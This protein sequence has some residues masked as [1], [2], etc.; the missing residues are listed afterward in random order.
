MMRRI[1][2]GEPVF[3]VHNCSPERIGKEM[4][5]EELH[6]FAVEVLMSE[7]GETKSRVL[8]YDKQSSFE[9]DF[10]FMNSGKIPGFT[11]DSNSCKTVNVLVVYKDSLDTDISDIDTTWLVEDYHR[12]GKIPR[13]TIATS[14]CISDNSENGKP[15]ICGGQFCFIYHSIGLVPDEINQP[16]DKELSAVELAS[17]YAEAWDKKDAS[18]VA[19]YLDKDFHYGSDWVFDEMPSRFE[20][21]SYFQGKL[22]SIKRGSND[23]KSYVGRNHQTGDVAVILVQN[24]VYSALNIQTENGRITSGC[25][26]KH[27]E[28]LKIFNPADE[29]YQHHGDHLECIMPVEELIPKQMNMILG[30]SKLWRLENTEVTTEEIYE[31]KTRVFSLMY[32]DGD[33]NILSL[34]ATS[35]EQNQII[36]IYP[37]AKGSS[38]RVRIEKVIEWDNQ[39]EATVI[40]SIGSFQFA[41][42]A[43]DYYC[44]KS[45][46]KI[47]ETISVDISSLGMKVSEGQRGFQFE[48]Q[49]AIDWLAKIGKEPNFDQEGNVEPIH[50]GLENLVAFI[51]SNTKCPNEAE[52]QSPGSG[53]EICSILNTDF[54]KT[55]IMICRREIE[56]EI[57]VS[58]PLYFRK[59]YFPDFK[60]ND[61]VCGMIWIIGNI[62]GMHDEVAIESK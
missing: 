15:A 11:G 21:L 32:G 8:K 33:M 5:D 35:N 2:N 12:N 41:F 45:L 62:S 9:A 6:D 16:L 50:F 3:H 24:G 7:Y 34:I 1:S 25:M 39:I 42:F 51:D 36:S 29:V 55:N 49:K 18:I 23:V 26:K 31:Q 46:Y 58:I 53:V 4:T 17:K 19:P 20:Y 22:N 37:I 13:I 43:V 47:G 56:E 48:G 57:E 54:Y 38:Y 52:F 44:N 61:P 59:D 60:D 10:C 14:W 28:R 40:C 27:D 30:E